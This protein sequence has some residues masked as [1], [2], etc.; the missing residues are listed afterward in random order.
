MN[1]IDPICWMQ[2]TIH[3][4][5]H[6]F[7][8]QHCVKIFEEQEWLDTETPTSSSPKKDNKRIAYVLI[9]VILLWWIFSWRFGVIR[10]FMWAFFVL[11]AILKLLD[12]KW[13]VTAYAKY[14][15][16]AMR[17]SSWWWIYPYIELAIWVWFLL[18]LYIEIIAWLTLVLMSIWT[19]WV[20]K[21]LM[22]KEKFAC[23]CLWTK[24]NVPLTNLTLVEDILMAIMSVMLLLG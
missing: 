1:K 18:W 12:H 14:D 19:I 4:H 16:I 2:W 24:L 8:S 3:Q 13:F 7:C 5:N 23:A 9:A 21:K 22:K 10:E 11:V 15:L 20:S 6:W 17:Y